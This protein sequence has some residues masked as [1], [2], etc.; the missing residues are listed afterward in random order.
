MK[1][2]DQQDDADGGDHLPDRRKH[3]PVHISLLEPWLNI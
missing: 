2:D 3:F 1:D